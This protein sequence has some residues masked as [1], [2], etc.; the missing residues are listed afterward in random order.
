MCIILYIYPH[1]GIC[2]FCLKKGYIKIRNDAGI[3]K[4]TQVTPS[5]LKLM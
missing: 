3:I 2:I 1:V 5:E 4:V